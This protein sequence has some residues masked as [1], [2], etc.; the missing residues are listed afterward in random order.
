[1][2]NFPSKKFLFVSLEGLSDDLAWQIKKEGH[3]VKFYI[4]D[5]RN[6]DVGD[7]FVEKIDSWE[8]SVGRADVIVFD[9]TG[10]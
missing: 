1:M 6:K 9:D 8:D 3:Q 7:G 10:F 5:E 2:N 4:K